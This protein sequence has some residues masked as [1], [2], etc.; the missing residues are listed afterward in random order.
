MDAGDLLAECGFELQHTVI[1]AA[2]QKREGR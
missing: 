1:V 2:K